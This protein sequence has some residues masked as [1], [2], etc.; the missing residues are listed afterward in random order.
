MK[1]LSSKF[2]SDETPTCLPV[3]TGRCRLGYSFA[4]YIT[5]E[6]DFSLRVAQISQIGEECLFH[7]LQNQ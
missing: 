7:N 2:W 3:E 5:A 1:N 4:V 6:T